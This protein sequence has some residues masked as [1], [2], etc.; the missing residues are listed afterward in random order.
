MSFKV[1]IG[2]LQFEEGL[3]AEE[4]QV[5]NISCCHCY[6]TKSIAIR[7]GY[8]DRGNLIECSSIEAPI[9]EQLSDDVLEDF[10]NET[11]RI[12]TE[13]KNRAYR[14]IQQ[15]LAE[16]YRDNIVHNGENYDNKSRK[17]KSKRKRLK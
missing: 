9:G 8:N 15:D 6:G 3:I 12:A 2:E 11:Y 7:E 5:G 13:N 17:R 10:W 16:G 4:R 1:N 14:Y